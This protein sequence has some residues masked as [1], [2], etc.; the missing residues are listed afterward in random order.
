VP[1]NNSYSY[2]TANKH[3]FGTAN[4]EFSLTSVPASITQFGAAMDKPLTDIR[5]DAAAGKTTLHF[6]GG[7]GVDDLIIRNQETGPVYDLQ[8]RKVDSTTRGIYIQEG[9]KCLIRF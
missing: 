2:K 7:T 3:L 6:R 1:A 9:K 5:Y 4:H 8:G